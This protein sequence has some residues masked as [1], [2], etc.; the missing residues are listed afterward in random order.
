MG[1]QGGYVL[2]VAAME[3]GSIEE[4]EY[5]RFIDDFRHRGLLLWRAR[6]QEFTM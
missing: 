6:V 3:W 5:R 2:H 4:K 1:W